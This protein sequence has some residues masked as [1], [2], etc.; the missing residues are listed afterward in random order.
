MTF[1]DETVAG[2]TGGPPT[3][4]ATDRVDGRF[5]LTALV[6]RG[7]GIDTYAG[8]DHL[9]ATDVLVKT[10][11]TASMPTA[12]YMRLEHEARLLERIDLGRTRRV[13]WCGQRDR[14]FYLVQ[15]RVEGEPLDLVLT[16][17]QL[18]VEM[19]LR[20]AISILST[21][22][23]VHQH[24]V[25][26]RDIKPSNIIVRGEGADLTAELVDFG[27]SRGADLD[28]ASR[29]E[30]AGTV[31]YIA[32]EA[33]GLINVV[34]D[35]PSDLYS[36]GVVMFE[37][38]A[39]H[40]P[41]SGDTVGEVLRQHLNADAPPLRSLG[42]AVPRSLDGVLHRLLAKD[43]GGRYQSAASV[44][45]DL[46]QIA[47]ALEAGLDEPAV[48]PGR[49]DRRQVLAEPAFIGRR[50]E[51]AE[52]VAVLDD[53]DDTLQRL[54][55]VEADS[56]AGKTRL[57][58]E[59][60]LHAAQRDVVVLRGQG[61][62]QGAPRPFQMLEGLADGIV[63]GDVDGML[64][65]GL[66]AQLSERADAA[67]ATLPVLGP[68]LGPVDRARL[69]PEEYGETRS[70]EALLALLEALGQ[71]PR[72]VLILLDDCQWADAMTLSLLDRWQSLEVPRTGRGVVIV[73]SFRSED[74]PVGHPL[75]N[76][77]PTAS[78]VLRPF[79]ARSIEQLSESMAGPLPA[80]AIE[81]VVRLAG[82]SPFMA[83]AVLRG[84]VETGALRHRP[85][86]WEIDPGPM[87]DVQTSRRA[88]L[89]SVPSLR[90]AGRR[91]SALPHRR[92]RPRQGVRPRPGHCALGPGSR[93]GH[94]GARR[95]PAAAHPLGA[96]GRRPL[97]LHPRQ[98]AREPA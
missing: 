65:G 13:L 97:L 89:D 20:L 10:V 1:T 66:R 69:G 70:I 4:S 85:E 41:F 40:T 54:V 68:L 79:D 67:A 84:M 60:A 9:H 25:L 36:L 56:G 33:A 52:L 24:G 26:H 21:L 63:V 81:A 76:L 46:T 35:Q 42:L 96:R 6:K 32:P 51:L 71:A 95:C 27:L 48:T 18:S 50:E 12:V 45:D 61:V 22:H 14:Y 17:G 28:G 38:L 92:R 31:R 58:D 55:L 7:N 3:M 77:D 29:G 30:P 83:S 72:P 98:V 5:E 90:P 19:S 93:R 64:A 47:A 34:V 91:G 2:A 86:G 23:Q 74:V 57:L 8:I 59:L 43:P 80:E 44:L 73:A 53:D 15:P 78:V 75:R 49:R 82:G 87:A 39:G 94:P 88:A 16:R 11:E 62:D 37:C